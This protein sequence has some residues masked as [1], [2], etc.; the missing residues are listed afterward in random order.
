MRPLCLP[1]CALLF[2]ALLISTRADDAQD[3]FKIGLAARDRLDG[4]QFDEALKLALQAI[5]LDPKNPWFHGLAGSA[6]WSLKRYEEGLRE[7]ETAIRLAN[8]KDDAW[9]FHLAGE[10]AY[11]GLDFPRARQYFEQAIARGGKE[12][13]GNLAIARGRLAALRERTVEFDWVL[14]PAKAPAFRR[15]DGT[16]L[17]PLPS[18]KHPFQTVHEMTVHG[19][20]SHRVEDFDGNEALAVKPHGDSPVRVHFRVTFKPYPYKDELARYRKDAPVPD[21]AR[22]YLGKSEWFD[23]HSPKLLEIVRPLSRDNPVETVEQILAYLRGRLRYVPNSTFTSAEDVLEQGKAI[24]HGWSAAFTGLCRAAGIP[25]RMVD[26]LHTDF[27]PDVL[28]YH[29]YGEFYVPGAGWIPVEPQPG[30][31]I[32]VPGPGQLRLYH[33]SVNRKWAGTNADEIHPLCTLKQLGVLAPKYTVVERPGW[34]ALFNGKDLTGWKLPERP[35]GFVDEVLK[36]EHDGKVL[37]YD[38]RLKNG[39]VFPLWRVEDGL[40][41]GS[42]PPSHLFS[43]RGDYVNFKLRVE[44]AIND[45][46]N[47]GLYFRARFGSGFP[48]GYEAQI[49]ATHS[50]RRKTGSLCLPDVERVWVLDNALHKPGEFFVQEVSCIGDTITISVNGRKTIDAWKDPEHRYQTGHIA[51]Q[52]HDRATVVKFRKIEVLELPARRGGTP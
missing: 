43:E 15:T 30:G 22:K 38:A 44:A 29:T 6:L 45:G 10:N 51:L 24:C 3:A 8:G 40:L 28:E 16:F 33:Y 7:C 52:G 35:S 46:G 12:L 47:S 41:I 48:K 36:V 23:P 50:D 25:A 39:K 4:G 5:R 34:V 49:N 31:L 27:K 32:G 37:G 14:Q 26:V 9:Y 18:S 19:A 42:G 2:T 1:A 11:S 17:V 21:E 13:G 20:A